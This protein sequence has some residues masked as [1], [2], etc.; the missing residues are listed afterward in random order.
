MNVKLST[1]TAPVAVFGCLLVYSDCQANWI[2]KCKADETKVKCVQI[3]V[4]SADGSITLEEPV[5]VQRGAKPKLVWIL[6]EG[7]VFNFNGGGVSLKD[8]TTEIGSP[9]GVSDDA[10]DDPNNW[11][12]RFKLKVNK[13]SLSKPYPYT[14]IFH[15]LNGGKATRKFV[16]DPT[17]ANS[18]TDPSARRGKKPVGADV[19]KRGVIQVK[20]TITAS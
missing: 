9:S 10:D 7:Y 11:S 17:I 8:S 19:G 2:D 14:L 5:Y 12:K 15:E 13:A 3:A 4:S 20:C 18:D 6:P 1:V 16:C